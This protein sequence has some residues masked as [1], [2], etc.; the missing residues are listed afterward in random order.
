MLERKWPEKYNPAGHLTWAGRL[1]GRGLTEAL[2]WRRGHIYHGTWGRAPFQSLYQPAVGLLAGL[3][4]MPEW[5][6]LI[7]ALGGL[8]GLG[9]LWTPL[10][11]AMPLLTLA[12][13]APLVQALT[14]AARASAAAPRSRGV[15]VTLLTALLHLL[16]P[17]ARLCGR[18]R[19]GLTPWR[20]RRRGSWAFPR[21]RLFTIWSEGWRAHSEWLRSLEALL[22]ADGA[23]V[24]RGGDFDR[25]DLEVRGGMLGS[26]RL[27]MVIEEHGAGRQFA[28]IRWWPRCSSAALVLPVVFAMLAAIAALDRAWTPTVLLGMIA[29]L[30]LLRTLLECAA[31]TDAVCQALERSGSKET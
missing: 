14:S 1:Y 15:R 26:S 5:Y 6:L 8:S 29:A 19:H 7:V 20:R 24:L 17:L 3:S 9:M 27:R 23:P 12:V 11:W 25:W 10:F 16:Q 4:L 28:R 22:R 30:L 2:T 31:A 13:A 21:P 18:L